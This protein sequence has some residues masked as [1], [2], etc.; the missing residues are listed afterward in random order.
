MTNITLT[1]AGAKAWATVNGPLTA[2]MV[3]I[4]VTIEYT[5]EW[6]GL[7]KNLV[8]RCGKW[9]PEKGETRT[10]LNVGESATVAHEVMQADT[11]LY[12]AVEGYSEDGNL[13]IPTTWTECGRIQHGAN[14]GADPSANPKLYVWNQLQTQIQQI[15]QTAVTQEQ[16][17]DIQ[18]W[19]QT[20]ETM[21]D[22][23][24][25]ALSAAEDAAER[26]AAA[27]DAL[28][29]QSGLPAYSAFDNGKVL[30]IVNGNPA[31]VE[32]AVSGGGSGGTS[33]PT[34]HGIVWD[35]VNVTS[36]NAAASVE[37]GGSLSAVLTAAEGYTLGT[38]T[39]TMGGEA[40]TGMWD[41]N[42]ST[43]T[44]ASV[45]GDVMISC[46]GVAIPQIVDTSPVVAQSNVGWYA[47]LTS[48][49]L[50]ATPT[51]FNGLCITRT[52][53]FT[54]NIE[55]IKASG[56]Y[57]A[58]ADCLTS[59]SPQYRIKAH[60]TS[61]EHV[62]AGGSTSGSSYYTKLC[63]L[64]DGVG[65]KLNSMPT[66]TVE[67]P[68]VA[69]LSF[70]V[71]DQMYANGVSFTLWEADIENAYAYWIDYNGYLP[72]GVRNGDI[73]FAGE[74][75]P[76]YGMSNIDGTMA[77]ETAVAMSF[78]N[79][80]AQDYTVATTSIMGE[81][82]AIDP[83]G[84]YGLTSDFATVIDE[85]RQEWMLEYGG[86][87]RKIPIIISTDQHGRTNAGIF[88]MIGRS[89]SMHDISKVM[90]LGDT[91]ATDW[92]DADEAHPLLSNT[93]LEAWCKSVKEIPFSKQLNVFGNHDCCYGN[94]ADE[95]NPIG[96]RY[97]D[98]KAHLYQY[99]RNIYARRTNNN[100]W[101]SVKDDAFNVK[102]VVY[103]LYQWPNGLDN[104]NSVHTEQ[105]EWFID[106][107][108]ADDGY[109]IV[110]VAHEPFNLNCTTANYP[111]N[112]TLQDVTWQRGI[113]LEAVID[114]RLNKTTGTT[115]DGSGVTH[116][117]DFSDCTSELLCSLHGHT[118]EDQYAYTQGGM[119]QPAFDWFDNNTFFMVLIDRVER[120]L[121]IWKIEAPN[122]VPAYTN[123]QIPLDEPAE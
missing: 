96:T 59:T 105:M 72:V 117:F 98:S 79:D 111:T 21:A 11:Y 113:A 83:D 16:V 112:G 7:T 38:V 42:T 20:A 57:D 101:F 39:V 85:A 89:F 56:Y 26:A 71:T 14:A 88:N 53:E 15:R 116:T 55:A 78:D 90:N 33:A 99:F 95:G 69:A 106:E 25:Q 92:Y 32:A 121:N 81:D 5:D 80:L 68:G 62:A 9:G 40:V 4:P 1:V 54:P 77:G 82:L 93:E 118:H 74:N 75:T 84:A 115:T 29:N 41:D 24:L 122:S 45:T 66:G 2:G 8:C 36:S 58:E 76:Y 103:S 91:L 10:I 44:I 73:I 49:D 100:G 6:I 102:Y 107:L 28:E 86:D 37:D 27:A 64:R 87:Y 46:A 120:E 51:A 60:T 47:G 12:L 110:I 52:Y 114:A 104:G 119:L 35:L 94:Y 23:A 61:T 108:S 70:N 63:W 30:G 18:T 22:N 109:D 48:T 67:N 65:I 17:G 13:V 97:P 3:G 43:V 19:A 123:Y 34:T 50:P 31:W